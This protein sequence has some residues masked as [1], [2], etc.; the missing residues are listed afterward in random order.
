MSAVNYAALVDDYLDA[1]RQIMALVDRCGERFEAS[2]VEIARQN[3]RELL[4]DGLFYAVSDEL[5]QDQEREFCRLL[6]A[7]R[8]GSNNAA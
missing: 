5:T 3:T 8:E 6:T 7:T 1:E 2:G 4:R